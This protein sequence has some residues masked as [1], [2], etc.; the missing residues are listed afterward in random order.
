MTQGAIAVENP[1]CRLPAV[2]P[3]VLEE[4]AALIAAF[5][6]RARPMHRVDQTLLPE[7]F[8]GRHDAPVVVLGLNPGWRSDDAAWHVDPEFVA[9]SRANLE[10]RPLAFPF[11]LLDPSL[12]APGC[13]WWSRKLWRPIEA[14]G[15]DAVAHRL[16]C[17]EFF[18]YHSHRYGSGVPRLPSQEFGFDVVRAAIGRE[19]VIVVMRSARRWEAAVPELI[20]YRRR[21]DLRN[22]QNVA[23]SPANCPEGYGEIV[24]A[25]RMGR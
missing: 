16:L 10:Q 3:H 6:R 14:V 13:R 9:R 18:G 12:S 2:P 24:D 25:L 4:D 20:G 7:P 22:V 21:F 17:V 5:N 23:I 8:L 15:L 1:W 11:Y 19:A